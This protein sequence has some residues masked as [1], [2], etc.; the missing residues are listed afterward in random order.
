MKGKLFKLLT[1]EI[2][3]LIILGTSVYIYLKAP[4][5]FPEFPKIVGAVILIITL[6]IVSIKIN[7]KDVIKKAITLFL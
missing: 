1:L 2:L 7:F 3:L 6:K 4:E 5:T